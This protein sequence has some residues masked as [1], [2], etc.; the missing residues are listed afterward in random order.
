MILSSHSLAVER[1]RWKERRKPVV[2]KEWRLCRFCYVH[3][4]DPAHAMFVCDHPDLVELRSVFTNKVDQEL[5]GIIAQFSQSALQLF[6][7]LLARREITPL[8]GKLAFDVQKIF[9][10]TPILLVCEPMLRT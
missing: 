4:E 8:L 7:G 5:P 10:A 3:I 2:P 1:R 6:K 9:D